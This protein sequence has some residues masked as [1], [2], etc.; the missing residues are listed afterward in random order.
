[1]GLPILPFGIAFK[2]QEWILLTEL[3]VFATIG[4]TRQLMLL[5]LAYDIANLCPNSDQR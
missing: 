4:M 1:V 2:T 3:G 5:S